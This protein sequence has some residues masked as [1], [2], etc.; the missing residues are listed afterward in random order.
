MPPPPRPDI[1]RMRSLHN[2]DVTEQINRRPDAVADRR[3]HGRVRVQE[4]DCEGLGKVIDISA[5]GLRVARRRGRLYDEGLLL[6]VRISHGD[7]SVVLP[8]KIVRAGKQP[9]LGTVHALTFLALDAGQKRQLQRMVAGAWNMLT[10]G[11]A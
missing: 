9:G 7:Q 6:K 4:T 8:A 5:S 3:R 10:V 1:D 2:Q 11:A